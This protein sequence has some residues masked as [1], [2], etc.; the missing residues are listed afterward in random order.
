M[1]FM[2]TYYYEYVT[3]P[4]EMI[5]YLRNYALYNE[6]QA[7]LQKQAFEGDDIY[8]KKPGVG[9]RTVGKKKKNQNQDEDN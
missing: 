4:N 7:L 1:T 5:E 2:F 3:S 8:K 6:E 9:G